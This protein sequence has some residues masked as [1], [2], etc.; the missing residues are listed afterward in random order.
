MVEHVHALVRKNK[1]LG[2]A[3]DTNYRPV[4]NEDVTKEL[5]I[6]TVHSSEHRAGWT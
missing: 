5:K 3:C 1:E 2:P 6:Q 4:V